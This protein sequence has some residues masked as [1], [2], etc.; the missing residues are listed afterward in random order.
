MRLCLGATRTNTTAT[1]KG[2]ARKRNFAQKIITGVTG[3][4]LNSI[5]S[6]GMWISCVPVRLVHPARPA[7]ASAL[8]TSRASRS[9]QQ[10]VVLYTSN[11]HKPLK[12]GSRHLSAPG[13]CRIIA[14]RQRK[15]TGV[16][17]M[18][19]QNPGIV[20]FLLID[21]GDVP[22]NHGRNH[23]PGPVA[24]PPRTTAEARP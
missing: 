22:V 11:P 12:L 23:A 5:Y 4:S 7:G 1:S 13:V 10:R 15:M 3:H 9:R 6:V 24:P 18:S 19:E 17:L 8:S 14:S 21:C 16:S 20:G 2:A